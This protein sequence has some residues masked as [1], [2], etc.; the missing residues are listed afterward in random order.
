VS[1]T[2]QKSMVTMSFREILLFKAY[3]LNDIASLVFRPLLACVGIIGRTYVTVHGKQIF[4]MSILLSPEFLEVTL[5]KH[6]RKNFLVHA[7]VSK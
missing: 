5:L 3:C 1:H 2:R 6:W 4:Q 7:N